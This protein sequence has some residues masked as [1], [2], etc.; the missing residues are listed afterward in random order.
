LSEILVVLTISFDAVYWVI[1]KNREMKNEKP[2]RSIREY[3]KILADF[4]PL[5]SVFFF[6]HFIF[7]QTKKRRAK[8]RNAI[9]I[10][11]GKTTS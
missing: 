3:P 7:N 5:I 4:L 1:K 9:E 2:A 6:F 10:R 8:N 11:R